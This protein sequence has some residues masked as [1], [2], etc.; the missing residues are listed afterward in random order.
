M[1]KNFHIMSIIANLLMLGM[2]SFAF[3][4]WFF[5]LTPFQEALQMPSGLAIFTDL[6][7]VAALPFAVA[8]VLTVV[9]DFVCLFSASKRVP[10]F[11]RII[12]LVSVSSLLVGLVISYAYVL[13]VSSKG[14]LLVVFGL[15]DSLWLRTVLPIASTI[16]FLVL[17]W[18]PKTHPLHSLWSLLPGSAY[19]IATF[20]AGKNETVEIS[21]KIFD[22]AQHEWFICVL[23]AAI[24][25]LAIVLFAFV[26]SLAR[27]GIGRAFALRVAKSPAAEAGISEQELFSHEDLAYLNAHKEEENASPVV[28]EEKPLEGV[29]DEQAPKASEEAK[30]PKEKK[31]AAKAKVEK[32]TPRKK[33]PEGE[34]VIEEADEDSAEAEEAQELQE[35]EQEAKTGRYMNKPRVYHV[36]KQKNGKKWQVKLATGKKAIKL[37]NTQKEA[38]QYAK[39]LV[40]TQGGSIRLH[41]LKGKMRK[42]K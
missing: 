4:C 1:R 36:S 18:D 31:P 9:F 14:D 42:E 24:V 12:K 27:N 2:V 5:K 39:E 20:V 23:Y 40:K 35:I 38:L 6:S 26:L 33:E 15:N 7:A 41:S 16:S 28:G 25:L 11:V 34:I 13:P 3:C 19:I 8:A 17:E 32:K 21:Y 37:L 29:K 10:G 30:T 22:P